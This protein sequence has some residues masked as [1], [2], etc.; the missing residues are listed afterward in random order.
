MTIKLR[1]FRVLGLLAVLLASAC[2]PAG[3]EAPPVAT[4]RGPNLEATDPSTVSLG[5]GQIQFVE[6]FRFT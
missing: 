2:G 1:L 4:S 3:T 6:F 5:S